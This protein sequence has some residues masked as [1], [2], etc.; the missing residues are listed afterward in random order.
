MENKGYIRE[1]RPLAEFFSDSGVILR[2]FCG[3][4]WKREMSI[5]HSKRNNDMTH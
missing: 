5:L 4:E 3:V 1:S 2:R